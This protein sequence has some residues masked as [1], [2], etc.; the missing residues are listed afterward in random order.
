VDKFP[1][2]LLI[3]PDGCAA[4]SL[5][6]RSR[7]VPLER[8]APVPIARVLRTRRTQ[9]RG[10]HAITRPPL[11]MLTRP[12]VRVQR[13]ARP[14]APTRFRSRRLPLWGG[15]HDG[16]RRDLGR[17][18]H[19]LAARRGHV[20]S[21]QA[22][23]HARFG[24]PATRYLLLRP[25]HLLPTAYC[26]KLYFRRS[27]THWRLSSAS[28]RSSRSCCGACGVR[29]RRETRSSKR[30]SGCGEEG[31]LLLCRSPELVVRT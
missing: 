4:L 19:L 26:V 21:G 2:V 15:A 5:V 16:A 23:E 12:R 25:Y 27:C 18:I 28:R 8:S 9:P 30:N 10:V 13:A 22:G 29:L 1:A 31:L 6:G 24:R 17:C 14:A 20:A 7:V 3:D 11:T